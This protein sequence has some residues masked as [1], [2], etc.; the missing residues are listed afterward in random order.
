[1]VCDRP[2]HDFGALENTQVVN[3]VFTLRNEGDETAV[4]KQVV[5]SCS[6]L[7]ATPSSGQVSP[8]ETLGLRLSVDLRGRTGPQNKPVYVVW[9]TSAQ[10]RLP[11][12][13]ALVGQA[14][15][16]VEFSPLSASFGVVGTTG[17]VQRTVRVFS[18][19]SNQTVR[20]TGAACS[21]ERFEARVQAVEPDKAYEVLV[22]ARDPR[23]PSSVSAI[24]TIH[25]D[26]PRY[27]TLNVPIYMR[28]HADP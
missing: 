10:D 18:T 6:C 23:S 12:R 16:A 4:F 19:V 27:S 21:D 5:S 8:G 11:L 2:L 25:T 9:N 3:H 26:H 20:V 22:S 1:M 17:A 15:A 14:T 28:V 13:L 7:S 24:L